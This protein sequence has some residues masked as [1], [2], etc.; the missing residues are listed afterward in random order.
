MSQT[1]ITT[2]FEALKAQ[3]AAANTPVVLDEFVFANVPN[4]NIT[5]P[6]DPAEAM[7]TAGQ[8]VH[9]A[10]VGKTGVVNANAVVYSITLGADVG[11][12]SFNWVGLRD[13]TSNTLAMIVHAPVQQK[14]K[15]NAGTQGNVLTRSFLMEYDGAKKETQIA[16]PAGTWQIDFT[17]R[18]AGMDERHRVENIDVYGTGAFIGDGFLVKRSGNNYSVTAGA[19][20]VGGLRA[21]LAAEQALTVATK[22]VKVWVDTS[23]TGTLTS[24]WQVSTTVTVADTL[25]DYVKND[26]NHYVFAVAQINADGSVTD[27]RKNI[28][29]LKQENNL[30]D[31]P[32]KG[33]ARQALELKA[34]AQR[35]IGTAP[36]NV[37]EIGGLGFGLSS[38]SITAAF[39]WQQADFRNAE[40]HFVN[41][42]SWKNAPVLPGITGSV[43][44]EVVGVR[45]VPGCMVRVI[46]NA[47]MNL[48]SFLVS[49]TGAKGSRTFEVVE[50]LT[51]NSDVIFGDTCRAA[52]FVG[53]A[54]DLP[55][56]RHAI[57]DTAIT[58]ATLSALN[59]G[60]ALKPGTDGCELVGF[61]GNDE[62]RPYVRRKS[63]GTNI[64]LATADSV[65]QRLEQKANLASPAL[66]G[67]PTAPTA[68]QTVSSTQIATT[69]FVKAALSALVNSSP[70]ALDTLKELAD[71]LGND[72][73]FATTMTNALANKIDGDTCGAAGFVGGAAGSPYLR[74]KTTDTVI[75]I[76]TTAAMNNGLALKP[77]TDGCELVGFFGN[78]KGRPYVKQKSSGEN[79]VLATAENLTNRLAEK[80]DTSGFAG[81]LGPTTGNQQLGAGKLIV[82]YGEFSI[83]AAAG[84]NTTVTFN[85]AF[86]NA[87]VAVIPTPGS[88]GSAEQLGASG[89]NKT[90]ATIT[91]GIGDVNARAGFY[92]ALGY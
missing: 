46:S 20:Y 11:D 84:S 80:M 3:Q 58:L 64:I 77:G 57:S 73:N 34:A 61:F 24:V 37:I 17:A 35:D 47:G 68:A 59:N 19:G 74:H 40:H 28:A 26:V 30:A 23:F 67:T 56:M 32:D 87:C 39:D 81:T 62:G 52:G 2:A 14:V 51:R 71:A 86:P 54:V 8:I 79:I 9:R 60:L 72:A 31:V 43:Y 65:T 76:A 33:R 53:G 48:L 41:Q 69:A 1:V 82:Q 45:D 55:Y 21:V 75:M 7:P 44:L 27:L 18:L 85:R 50:S 78:D 29:F 42:S 16:T 70:A 63:S 10:G 66:T 88:G 91:K 89:K 22:P 13:K 90:Q 38:Q 6:I 4:L 25:A 49:V 15:N 36:G 5:D 92:V 12:F 83:G